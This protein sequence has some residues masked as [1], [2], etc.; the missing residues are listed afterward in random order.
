MRLLYFLFSIVFFCKS[1]LSVSMVS[2]D[3]YVPNS[4]KIERAVFLSTMSTD[5]KIDGLKSFFN[6][7]A[8]E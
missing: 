7:E 3:K 1:Y 6:S 5:V 4:V 2:V 8:P